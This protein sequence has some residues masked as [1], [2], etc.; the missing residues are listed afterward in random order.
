MYNATCSSR[1]SMHGMVLFCPRKVVSKFCVFVCSIAALL[2]KYATWWTT[3]KHPMCASV[4]H[5]QKTKQSFAVAKPS[6][7]IGMRKPNFCPYNAVMSC[8]RPRAPPAA[9]PLHKL[10]SLVQLLLICCMLKHRTSDSAASRRNTTNRFL[11]ILKCFPAYR[12]RPTLVPLPI[13]MPCYSWWKAT[14]C[15]TGSSAAS[16]SSS[17]GPSNSLKGS[18]SSAASSSAAKPVQGAPGHSPAAQ[19]S[20]TGPSGRT[21]APANAAYPPSTSGSVGSAAANPP[22][23]QQKP[24]HVHCR[25]FKSKTAFWSVEWHVV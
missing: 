6:H 23:G 12:S 16:A 25:Q 4:T 18:P 21:G 11:S 7:V 22:T 9:V 8:V 3:S 14:R 20:S 17:K 24:Q 2:C 15:L 13:C 10:H 1:Y 19:G 5:S